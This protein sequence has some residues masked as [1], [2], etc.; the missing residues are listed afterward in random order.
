MRIFMV[1]NTFAA[2]EIAQILNTWFKENA[3]QFPW[4]KHTDPYQIFIAEYMLQQTQATRVAS[5]FEK[6]IQIFPDI[7]QLAKAPID[8]VLKA[9]E[10]MGYYRRFILLHQAAQSIVER[11]HG[12]I[13]NSPEQLIQL[14]GIGPYISCSIAAIAFNYPCIAIDTNVRRVLMRLNGLE[15]EIEWKEFHNNF[16]SLKSVIFEYCSPSVFSQALMDFASLIC[17]ANNPRCNVCIF[18]EYCVALAL[19]KQKNIPPRAPK[20]TKKYRKL[21]Y[22]FLYDP[23]VKKFCMTYR[24]NKHDIW[25]GMWEFPVAEELEHISTTSPTSFLQKLHFYDISENEIFFMDEITHVLTHQKIIAKFYV[26]Q[27]K[28]DKYQHL[29][30]IFVTLEDMQRLYPVHN[31]LKKFFLRNKEIIQKLL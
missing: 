25:Y 31:L 12:K 26:C 16:R 14:P 13:P 30:Y 29:P 9:T 4:R 1:Q 5:Y 21:H 6:F 11:F 28:I 20:K 7:A 27:L 18:R 23:V 8:Q 3:R 2:Q 22:F 15:N 24:G 19:G 10:G 17:T